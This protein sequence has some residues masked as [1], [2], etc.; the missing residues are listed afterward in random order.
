[1]KNFKDVYQYIL[2]GIVI[3]LVFFIVIA[4]IFIPIPAGNK[5]ILY[6][7]IGLVAGWGGAVINF[8]FGSNKES[9]TKTDMIYNST[10]TIP[11]PPPINV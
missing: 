10:P 7:I 8:N 2:G 4:L 9:A 5:E 3:L 6:A 1:M 11:T